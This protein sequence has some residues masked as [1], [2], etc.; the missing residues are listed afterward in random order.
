MISIIIRT[1]NEERWI[2]SC[3]QAVF[4]QTYKDIEV[5]I[6]DNNST[7]KTLEKARMFDVKIINIDEFLPGNAINMGIRA[8]VGEYIVCLSSH[9]IPID[10]SWLHTLIENFDDESVAGVYGRQEPMSYSTDFDKRDLLI[11]FG[12]DKRVQIKDSFFHNANSMIK[13]DV[14][15]RFPFNEHVTNIEDRVWAKEVLENDYRIIYEPEA[16][17][18]HYHGIHQNGNQERCANVVSIIESLEPINKDYNL[19]I[20]KMNIIALIPMKGKVEYL[21]SK[22][23]IEYTLQH[24]LN[25]KY[26]NQVIVLTDNPEIAE[27][28]RRAGAEIPFIRDDNLSAQHVDLATVLS[29]SLNKLEDMNILPD[30]VAILEP[31][32]PFRPQGLIDDLIVQLVSRGFDTVIPGMPEYGSCWIDKNNK[33]ERVDEGD[34][35]RILKTPVHI[36]LKGVGCVTY[37]VYVREKRIFDDNVGILEIFEPHCSIET[38]DDIGFEMADKLIGDFLNKNMGLVS[39]G[40]K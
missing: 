23:L 27:I 15:E 26:I 22:P 20:N 4:D 35:P 37:P 40:E 10:N 2:T 36:G 8:S 19:D 31:T 7:D 32:F 39:N 29:D 21:K 6:V 34:I 13:R 24:A 25:S 18:Y 17:V 33:I 11:T 5:I 3:L 9:C 16:S 38:R 1:K 28:S 14:W 30:I 12:L